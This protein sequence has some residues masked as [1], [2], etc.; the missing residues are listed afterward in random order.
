[1]ILKVL[2]RIL[3][4]LILVGVLGV[5]SIDKVLILKEDISWAITSIKTRGVRAS[6]GSY[7]GS[8]VLDICSEMC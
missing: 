6:I 8:K 7:I 1:V 3:G 5:V 2:G 4:T